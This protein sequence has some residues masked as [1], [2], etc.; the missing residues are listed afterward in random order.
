MFWTKELTE[1]LNKKKKQRVD[2][3]WSTS[4]FA[5]IGSLRGAVIHQIAFNALRKA[6][7]DV[8]YTFLMDDFD[9]MDGLP[10]YLDKSYEKE[11]GK[12]LFTIESP[13]KGKSL[14]QYFADDFLATL[15]NA[16]VIPAILWTSKIYKEGKFNEEIKDALD[17]ADK[18]R[19]IYKKISGAERPKNWYPFNPICE[20]CGKIG[21]TKVSD[22]DGEIV[23]YKCHKKAVEWAEGCEYEGKVSPFNGTGKMPWRVEWPARWKALGITVEGEGKDHWSAGGSREMADILARE[24]FD[25]TPPYDLK[26]DFFV[27][28]GKKMSS[29]KGTGINARAMSELLPSSVL[30]FLLASNPR[31]VIEFDPKG[32]TIP[33]LYDQY[34]RAREAYFGRLEF[35][36]IAKAFEISQIEK[37]IDGYVM[38]FIKVAYAIQMPRVEIHKLAEEEKGSKLI[39]LEK[40]DIDGRIHYAKKWLKDF[41]PEDYVFEVKEKL[42]KEV[43]ELADDQINFLKELGSRLKEAKWDG[44]VIHTLIHDLKNETG[45]APKEAFQAIYFIFLGKNSGPQAGWLISS[46]EKG[47]V[48]ERIEEVSQNKYE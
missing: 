14:A 25:Y 18:I 39:A 22:W 36:D 3:A 26:Y 46:L 41:A 24:V 10:S 34:D 40:E 44:Q 35:S 19:E 48:L 42:P 47:F 38:R 28:G 27:I 5:H 30:N 33:R 2:D 15:K 7:F 20:N 23:S 45:I 4:G 8:D 32:D 17:N 1:G 37:P 11:M 43:K 13:E 29:S 31:K 21:T 12:P 6:D 9:P 16:Q